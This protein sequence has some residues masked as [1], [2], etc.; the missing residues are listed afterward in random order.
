MMK[1]L[2]EKLK[3][4]WPKIIEEEI[5]KKVEEPLN[6]D[7]VKLEIQPRIEEGHKQLNNGITL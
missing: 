7:E 3:R 4:T 2:L 1:I 5:C 6:T